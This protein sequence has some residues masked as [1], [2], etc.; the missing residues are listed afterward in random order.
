MAISVLLQAPW[1]PLTV[2]TVHLCTCRFQAA[3]HLINGT[4]VAKFPLVLS[5]IMK[6]INVKVKLEM[7]GLGRSPALCLH[8]RGSVCTT[9]EHIALMD[10]ADMYACVRVRT[11]VCVVCVCV[12]QDASFTKEE[13]EQLG[14]VLGVDIEQLQTILE[15][16]SFVLEH[17]AY[18]V[19]KP[20]KA[21][22]LLEAAGFSEEHVRCSYTGALPRK[23]HF[24]DAFNANTHLI[25]GCGR[26][27]VCCCAGCRFP[28]RMGRPGRSA[29][30]AD[31]Q[32]AVRSSRFRFNHLGISH[33]GEFTWRLIIGEVSC[34]LH[35]LA[36]IQCKHGLT[37][38]VSS[39]TRAVSKP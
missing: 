37:H 23:C 22:A 5:R 32:H 6:M 38:G 2:S 20:D 39:I 17:F 31:A 15:S 3:V 13:K 19:M 27:L 26:L 29:C 30:D 11:H 10:V 34:R 25:H 12:L 14:A 28:K 4:D 1:Y 24:S 16:S 36:S 21:G 35:I 33:D 8:D 18:H 9:E 7:L